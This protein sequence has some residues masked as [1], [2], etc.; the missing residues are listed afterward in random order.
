M[1]QLWLQAS[2]AERVIPPGQIE[3]WLRGILLNLIRT[4]WR[5]QKRRA[6]DRPRVEPVLAHTL[7]ED[8]DPRADVL[9]LAGEDLLLLHYQA[10]DGGREIRDAI[11]FTTSAGAIAGYRHY[12][13]CPEVLVEIARASGARAGSNGYRY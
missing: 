1:Q 5:T 13:F 11:R 2:T 12:F 4:H 8:G 9:H 7:A 10:P 3:F 6:A